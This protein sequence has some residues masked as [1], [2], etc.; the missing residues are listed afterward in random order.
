MILDVRLWHD[1]SL[2]GTGTEKDPLRVA[3]GTASLSGDGTKAHPLVASDGGAISGSGTEAEPLHYEPKF[4][5]LEKILNGTMPEN[6]TTVTNY[7]RFDIGGAEPTN[8]TLNAIEPQEAKY[9]QVTF[10]QMSP[11]MIQYKVERPKGGAS[12]SFKLQLYV[13]YKPVS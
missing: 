3:K 12:V 9:W 13:Y 11:R 10:E 5:V 4:A 6:T 7:Y 2:V 8:I 1:D